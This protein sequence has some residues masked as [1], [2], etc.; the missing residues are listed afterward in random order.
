MNTGTRGRYERR[1][2][3]D[4]MIL[5]RTFQAAIADVWAAVTEPARM[6][7]WI[8]TW[9]GD[10]A[11]GS[12][13]FR[14]TAEG[15][16]ATGQSWDI[17]VCEPP[18]TWTVHTADESGVWSLEL[19]LIEEDGITTL[20]FTHVIHDPSVVETVGPGWEYYLDRLVAAETEED[21]AT[22]DFERDYYPALS[23]HYADIGKRA[24]P[25]GRPGE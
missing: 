1:D 22:M 13:S 12:V 3:Q 15:D 11:S 9:T 20:E 14:M 19:R 8:G 17:R 5:T 21:P 24:S 10:P 23:A 16:D 25:S 18:H 6:A 7:R 2:G 4:L